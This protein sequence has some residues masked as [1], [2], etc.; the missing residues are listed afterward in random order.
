MNEGTLKTKFYFH[1]VTSEGKITYGEVRM[2]V[3]KKPDVITMYK[4]LQLMGIKLSVCRGIILFTQG[5]TTMK[6]L[7]QSMVIVSI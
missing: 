4:H 5:W 6:N 1:S 3:H 2:V 7:L